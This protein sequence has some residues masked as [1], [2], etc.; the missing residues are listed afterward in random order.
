MFNVVIGAETGPEGLARTLNSLIPAIPEG[1]V[2]E[3]WIVDPAGRNEIERIADASGC[4]YSASK[5]A[6][7][8]EQAAGGGWTLLIEAGVVLEEGWWRE[9]AAFV[10]SARA[11]GAGLAVFTYADSRYGLRARIGE[12]VRTMPVVLSKPAARLRAR[13]I[14]PN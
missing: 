2:R 13:A 7:A 5:F 4:A 6:E 10:E 1:I 3:G 14:V 9:V 12:W 8:V 11:D